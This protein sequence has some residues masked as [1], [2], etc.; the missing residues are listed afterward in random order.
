MPKLIDLT[1]QI[2][3]RLTVIEKDNER[4][5]ESAYWKCKCTCGN[6]KSVRRDGLVNGRT[7]SCGCLNDEKRLT[8]KRKELPV[9]FKSGKLTVLEVDEEIHGHGLYY[10]CQCSC[11]NKVSVRGDALRTQKT[12]SCG[13]LVSLGEQTIS[14]LLR[15]KKIEFLQQ[16]NEKGMLLTTNRKPK[17]DFAIFKDSKLIF[18][19]EYNGKQH[20]KYSCGEKTWNNYENFK[21]MIRRDKEKE[22]IAKDFNYPLEIIRYDEDI[23][24]KL[25]QILQK[26]S[27]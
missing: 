11:G 5:G 26:Y 19:L 12:L 25:N 15:K 7:K 18:L 21:K 1:G 2:F 3:G 8:S 23:E 22:Q 16:Y 17:Y 14:E 20:Y 10:I 13:C 4:K 6:F 27:F 24:E 9:G